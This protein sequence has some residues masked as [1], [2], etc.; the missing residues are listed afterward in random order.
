MTFPTPFYHF[1]SMNDFFHLGFIFQEVV[2]L[3]SGKLFLIQ[4]DI[5]IDVESFHSFMI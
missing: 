5:R 4:M 2:F 1:L 3:Y